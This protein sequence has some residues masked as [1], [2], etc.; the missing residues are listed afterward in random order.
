[1]PGLSHEDTMSG[2]K[3]RQLSVRDYASGVMK[4]P[5]TLFQRVRGLIMIATLCELFSLRTLS[6]EESRIALDTNCKN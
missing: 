2:C 6:L 3:S 4:A 5:F 1:V